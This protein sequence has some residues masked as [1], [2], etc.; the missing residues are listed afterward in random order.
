M[1]NHSSLVIDAQARLGE[2]AIWDYD[3][4]ALW[5]IDIIPGK[6]H[7]YDPVTDSD[8]EWDM[9]QM[10]GTVVTRQSGG[11]VVALENGFAAFDPDS[12]ELSFLADPEEHIPTNRFNDGKCDPRGRFWAG[13]MAISEVPEAGAL[14]CL[15]N[16]QCSKHLENIS[17]SNGIVWTADQKTMYY[18]DSPTRKIEAFDY[19]IETGEISNRR[20]AVDVPEGVGNPDGMTIDTDDNVWVAMWGGWCVLQFDPRSGQLLERIEV[21][22]S[23]VTSCAFGGEDL[24]DLYITSARNNIE[25]SSNPDQPQGGGVF[26]YRTAARGV[27]AFAYGG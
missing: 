13:T 16:G 26:R 25:K 10:I 7:C 27:K 17:V 9:G 3:R 14:Y 11:L 1:A 24:Q 21:A 12:G 2:G 15:D 18:I 5:W 20:T 8:R 6:L 4:K 23:N 22:S 19:D